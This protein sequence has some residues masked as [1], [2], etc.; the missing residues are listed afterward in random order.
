MIE[1]LLNV[2]HV[3][4]LAIIALVILADVITKGAFFKKELYNAAL[5][6]LSSIGIA[7]GSFV[8][9]HHS[10][11]LIDPC[12]AYSAALIFVAVKLISSSVVKA[13]R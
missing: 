10:V 1:T 8:H 7:S 2:M 13:N 6:I 9:T 11:F 4:P 12:F 5:L 3:A